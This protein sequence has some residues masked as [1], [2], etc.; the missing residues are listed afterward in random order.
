MNFWKFL[1]RNV[2][3]FVIAFIVALCFAFGSCGD[4]KGCRVRR[5]DAVERGSQPTDAEVR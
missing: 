1:D 4:G 3:W 2:G 5:G